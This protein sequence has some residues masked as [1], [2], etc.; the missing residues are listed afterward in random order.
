MELRHNP[1]SN[2]YPDENVIYIGTLHTLLRICI[3]LRPFR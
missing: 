2:L 1:T 3:K